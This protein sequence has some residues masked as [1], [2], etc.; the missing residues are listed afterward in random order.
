MKASRN[1]GKSQ[2][3]AAFTLK[4]Q[5]VAQPFEHE[6][7]CDPFP[8]I[9]TNSNGSFASRR[10]NISKNEFS[11][12]SFS[13]SLP[14]SIDY[15]TPLGATRSP[16]QIHIG[17]FHKSKDNKSLTEG[18]NFT[19]LNKL[20]EVH[21]WA[22]DG[23]IRD[24]MTALN[25]DF[26]KTSIL[27][28]GMI[29]AGIIEGGQE[30]Q[31]AHVSSE[32]HVDTTSLAATQ[33]HHHGGSLNCSKD[34]S[35][36]SGNFSWDKTARR[37]IILG[38]PNSLP[39][40]PEWEDEDIYL[41]HRKDAIRAMRLASQ[42]SRAA[43]NAFLRNDH[44]SAKQ[45]SLKAREEWIDAERLN[46]QAAMK[47]LQIRNHKNDMSKLDLHGLHATEAI[48][49]LREHLQMLED[50]MSFN[51]SVSPSRNIKLPQNTGVVVRSSSFESL[52]SIDTGSSDLSC[53]ASRQRTSRL[54]VIT[55]VG[56]HSRGQAALPAAVRSFLNENGYHFDEVR[57]G[58]ITVR[59]KFRHR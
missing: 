30:R 55:G 43:K 20:R 23:L 11:S 16:S 34:E 27:L 37:K 53:H 52:K 9:A 22:D 35:D 15:P 44:K 40:E 4:Q 19:A 26:N 57:P 47:I 28:E 2:G 41:R 50:Q 49:A 25:N 56:N 7:R 3:W 54:Q 1:P 18:S 21:G 48:K 45:H 42:N 46:A 58:V 39:L 12:Q 32:K 8:P 10:N 24:I 33:E 17:V 13:S 29:S 31:E 51:R 14:S 38:S 5:R 36:F 6:N 59:L